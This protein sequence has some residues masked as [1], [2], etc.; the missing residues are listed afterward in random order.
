MFTLPAATPDTIPEDVPT[1]AHKVLL[2]VH[3]PPPREL[4][5]V[6]ELPAHTLEGPVMDGGVAFTVIGNTL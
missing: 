4:N 6:I 3:V 1:V 2:L 5:N